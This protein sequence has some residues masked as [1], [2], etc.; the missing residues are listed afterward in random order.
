[1]TNDQRSALLWAGVG[2]AVGF[3]AYGLIQK[4][5]LAGALI[6]GVIGGGVGGLAVNRSGLAGPSGSRLVAEAIGA[7]IG[8]AVGFWLFV[9]L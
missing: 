1:M 4:G 2:L 5:S 9:V 3:I 7:A 8:G 6:A